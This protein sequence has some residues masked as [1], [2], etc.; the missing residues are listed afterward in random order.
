MTRVSN[1]FGL[2]NTK[3]ELVHHGDDYWKLEL[4]GVE[5]E[6]GELEGWVIKELL[7]RL[8]DNANVRC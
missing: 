4:D 8:E 5:N 7:L 6:I 1:R 3:I 2:R